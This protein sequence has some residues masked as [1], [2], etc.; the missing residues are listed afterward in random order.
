ML[1]ETNEIMLLTIFLRSKDEE[2]MKKKQFFEKYN[3]MKH[4]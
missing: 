2:F 4:E 1:I 3:L